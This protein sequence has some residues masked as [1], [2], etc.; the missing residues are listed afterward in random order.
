MKIRRLFFVL[1]AVAVVL[2]CKSKPKPQPRQEPQ[3]QLQQS[4]RPTPTPEPQ[5]TEEALTP[6]ILERLVNMQDYTSI[7][8]YQFV[9][10]SQI[11]LIIARAMPN[12][13]SLPGGRAVFENIIVRSRI[14]FPNNSL[15]QALDKDDES[16]DEIRLR[17][18][19]EH[20]EDE[21]KYPP[22]TH[23]LVFSAKKSEPNSYFY[24]SFTPRP[25]SFLFSEERGNLKY[26]ENTYTLLSNENIP[27]LL[28]RLEQKTNA[29]EERRSPRGRSLNT[30]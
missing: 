7:S 10:S 28:L 25:E 18:C 27:Y 22:S 1:F 11:T 20:P 30:R 16:G 21:N 9:L 8:N 14:V 17:V 26:G 12:D 4:S 19:F 2:G 13:H 6:A 24:L 5:P 3:Q 29:N 15:G 23:Y